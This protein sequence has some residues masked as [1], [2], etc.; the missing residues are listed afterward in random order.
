MSTTP[1]NL[2]GTS[3]PHSHHHKGHR[4]RNFVLPNG[5][6]VHIA[7][8]PEEAKPLRRHL[9]AIEKDQP[10]DLVMNGSSEHLDALRVAHS[11]HENK[12]QELKN[13]HGHIYDEFENVKSDLDALV[14]ELH[15]LTDHSIAL[16]A[17]FSKYGYSAH[18]RA[19]DD[20]SG[21]SSSANS[22]YRGPD[23]HEKKDWAAE[24]RNGRI[25]KLYKKVKSY[26]YLK[27]HFIQNM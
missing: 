21:A 22:L 10:F 16:D 14:S 9:S 11:H 27:S 20:G 6:K 19:Y 24:K 18:L 5:R 12:R 3:T 23:D 13:K 25:M 1:S 2:H 17:S 7:P 8:S 26:S 4:L 15:M